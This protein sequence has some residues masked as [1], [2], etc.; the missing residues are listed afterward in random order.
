MGAA[1]RGPA[2]ARPSGAQ[3]AAVLAVQALVVAR[4]WLGTGGHWYV[5]RTPSMGRDAPVGT[6]LWVR[7]VD[8]RS[9]RV[10]DF[11]TFHPPG[12]NLVYSHRVYAI[13]AGGIRTKGT[14]GA[15]DG[16]IL[17]PRDLIGRVVMRWWAVGYLVDGLPVLL[18]G[19]VL[20]AL[21]RR[22]LRGDRRTAATAVG[23]AAVVSALIVALHPLTRA[24]LVAS[25]AEAGHERATYVS[26]GLLP[27]RL[28]AAGVHPVR[29][30]PGEQASIVVP[31]P[32]ADGRYHV[33]VVPAVPW[34]VWALI[35]GFGL[36]PGVHRT[37]RRRPAA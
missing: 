30:R 18:L 20:L 19:A 37:L 28:E 8:A 1:A 2:I 34:E 26:T 5:V 36:A 16:W 13:G 25:S 6:L 15:P 7:P 3:V 9:L 12:S 4:A 35:A 10:G 33:S 24:E 32:S 17:H 27:M 29:M 31:R 14:L 23:V 22:R 11:I 21:L